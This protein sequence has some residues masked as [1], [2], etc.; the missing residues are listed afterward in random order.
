[1]LV[2]AVIRNSLPGS[3]VC[4]FQLSDIVRS[5]EGAFKEQQTTQSAWMPVRDADVPSPHPAKVKCIL[6]STLQLIN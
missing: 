6:Y 4:A 5:F 1:M 3:A 2:C